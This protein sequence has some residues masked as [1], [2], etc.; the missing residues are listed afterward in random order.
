[1]NRAGMIKTSVDRKLRKLAKEY[2]LP[3]MKISA[4]DHRSVALYCF[5]ENQIQADSANIHLGLLSFYVDGKLLSHHHGALTPIWVARGDHL[6]TTRR[7]CLWFANKNIERATDYQSAA[8]F[9][10]HTI[11]L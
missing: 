8:L 6:I 2:A 10:L 7:S 9:Y 3:R 5:V 1:M 11:Q 4:T